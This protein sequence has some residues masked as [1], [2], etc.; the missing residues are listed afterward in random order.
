MTRNFPEM[1]MAQANAEKRQAGHA[2]SRALS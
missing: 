2:P 1:S